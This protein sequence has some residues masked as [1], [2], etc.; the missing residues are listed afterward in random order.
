[1]NEIGYWRPTGRVKNGKQ[2]CEWVRT[3]T[4][5]SR[6]LSSSFGEMRSAEVRSRLRSLAQ[7]KQRQERDRWFNSA[8]RVAMFPGILI[9]FWP[10]PKAWWNQPEAMRP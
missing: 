4:F 7:R 5:I 9:P 2:V 1:M 10:D 6:G 8:S 3:Q